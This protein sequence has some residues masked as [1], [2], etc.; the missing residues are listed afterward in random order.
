MLLCQ[1][2]GLEVTEPTHPRLELGARVS[3]SFFKILCLSH[4]GS[5]LLWQVDLKGPGSVLRVTDM[6]G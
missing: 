5:S 6:H 4:S 2:Q 3:P 1:H